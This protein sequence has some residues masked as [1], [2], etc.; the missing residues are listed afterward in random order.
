MNTRIQIHPSTY[1]FTCLYVCMYVC[2]QS[3]CT[4]DLQSLP[5]RSL[6]PSGLANNSGQ[7]PVHRSGS[8]VPGIDSRLDFRVVRSIAIQPHLIHVDSSSVTMRARAS[9]RTL[10]WER[11]KEKRR[12]P[13]EREKGRVSSRRIPRSKRHTKRE[14]S[15]VALPFGLSSKACTL[16]WEQE[17]FAPTSH[18]PNLLCYF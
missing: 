11:R 14:H 4:L 15:L 2:M 9:S 6:I 7:L 16:R 13:R 10:G 12:I 1:T 18:P 5:V 3:V 17:P 8:S